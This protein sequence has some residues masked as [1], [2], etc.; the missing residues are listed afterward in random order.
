MAENTTISDL[1]KKIKIKWWWR[2]LWTKGLI[3]RIIKQ[4]DE[5]VFLNQKN[6]FETNKTLIENLELKISEKINNLQK[7]DEEFNNLIQKNDKLESEKNSFLKYKSDYEVLKAKLVEADKKNDIL[8]NEKNQIQKQ[9]ENIEKLY[10]DFHTKIDNISIGVS[11]DSRILSKF[12]EKFDLS[13]NKDIGTF[14]EK[15]IEK[16]FEHYGIKKEY[17]FPQLYVNG[18]NVDFGFRLNPKEDIWIPIDSKGITFD[19]DAN[20]NPIIDDKLMKR[21]EAQA[22]KVATKYLNQKNTT[23]VGIMVVQDDNLYLGISRK[24]PHEIIKIF[25]KHKIIVV[26]TNLVFQWA[27]FLWRTLMFSMEIRHDRQ[28]V[29]DMKKLVTLVTNYMNDV[30]KA[31]ESLYYAINV[32]YDKIIQS[33]KKLC[34]NLD[35]VDNDSCRIR[36]DKKVKRET[37]I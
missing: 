20:K 19:I 24:Y 23:S 9:K 21:I 18:G 12:D 32:H 30:K 22:M 2:F 34:E 17:W 10:Q 29:E 6:L 11:N 7:R 4:I 27:H 26:S 8:N 1:K 5:N 33:H 15:L 37:I 28:I 3:N 16:N 35:L 25:E 14:C 31:K 36:P 13:N